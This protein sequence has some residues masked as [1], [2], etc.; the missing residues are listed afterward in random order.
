MWSEDVVFLSAPNA[1]AG[2]F[3]TILIAGK[4]FAIFAAVAVRSHRKE[5]VRRIRLNAAVGE[6][7]AAPRRCHDLGKQGGK[8]PKNET[9]VEFVGIATK[10]VN[11]ELTAARRGD[12]LHS[13]T[14]PIP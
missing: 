7:A 2:Q 12:I 3:Q 6:S 14:S 10:R 11:L 5:S 13:A 9:G 1:S 4:L 8:R